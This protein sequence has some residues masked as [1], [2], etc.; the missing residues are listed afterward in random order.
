[1]YRH[2]LR[3]SLAIFA[4]ATCV[5][6]GGVEIHSGHLSVPRLD[7]SLSDKSRILKDPDIGPRSNDSPIRRGSSSFSRV[8]RPR[9]NAPFELHAV[10]C[11]DPEWPEYKGHGDVH[12][13][14]IDHGALTFCE[15]DL[16][17][18]TLTT[19]DD[20][21]N[22][23]L[24]AWRW[25]YYDDRKIYQDYKVHWRVNCRTIQGFQDIEFPLGPNGP[26]CIDIMRDNYI[27]CNNGGI[28]GSTQAGC[29]VYTLHAGREGQYY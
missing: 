13:D 17:R 20:V 3:I 27:K 6:G 19:V 4:L 16:A 26:S 21:K 8:V 24:H 12:R 9:A 15:S 14:R 7:D 5:V 18:S 22:H 1:M 23:P 10:E 28:G 25:R 29:L 11:H 2:L